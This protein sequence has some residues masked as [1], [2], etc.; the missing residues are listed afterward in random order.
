MT[1]NLL[2]NVEKSSWNRKKFW[3]WCKTTASSVNNWKWS[4]CLWKT[5][6][7]HLHFC[8]N[9]LSVMVH[10]KPKKWPHTLWSVYGVIV[11]CCEKLK[12]H[13]QPQNE[14]KLL[15]S[16]ILIN[17]FTAPPQPTSHPVLTRP[18]AQAMGEGVCAPPK[19][20]KE[21]RNPNLGA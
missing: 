5:F 10:L 1:E 19:K 2:K 17:V 3:I 6:Y 8:D 20:K 18:C 4:R 14:L 11:W 16:T 12:R 21:G 13:F 9:T 15:T 7:K